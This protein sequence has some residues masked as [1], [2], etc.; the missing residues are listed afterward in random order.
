MVPLTTPELHEDDVGSRLVIT[1]RQSSATRPGSLVDLS[2]ALGATIRF[3]RPDRTMFDVEAELVQPEESGMNPGMD[4]RIEY[5][6]QEGD[7]I[8]A[9][10]WKFQVLLTLPTGVWSSNVLPFMVYPNLL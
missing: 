3:R 9:G 4:G 1:V 2:L 6:T 10:E 7:L 5:Y 8:P